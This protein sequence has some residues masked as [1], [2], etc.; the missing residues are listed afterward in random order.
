[1]KSLLALIILKL[2][3]IKK[4]RKKKFSNQGNNKETT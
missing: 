1:M 4:V 3:T 2:K